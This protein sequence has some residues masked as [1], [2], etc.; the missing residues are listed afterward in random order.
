[1]TCPK[2]KSDDLVVR[3]PRHTIDGKEIVRRRCCQ[4]CGHRWNTRE[5]D[6]ARLQSQPPLRL[7]QRAS[8]PTSPG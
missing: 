8:P 7:R 5:I 4:A 6:A 2:C 1:M 3:N